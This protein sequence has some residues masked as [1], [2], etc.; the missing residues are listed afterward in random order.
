MGQQ[1]SAR[2]E[3]E[4]MPAASSSRPASP[5][6]GKGSVLAGLTNRIKDANNDQ[7][8]KHDLRLNL[9]RGKKILPEYIK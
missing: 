3:D 7:P 6:S 9:R 4:K 1:K 5:E 8:D 2:F